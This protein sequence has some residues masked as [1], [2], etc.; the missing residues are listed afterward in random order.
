MTRPG[1]TAQHYQKIAK[2]FGASPRSSMADQY[3][4]QQEIRFIFS[5]I[6]NYCL[7]VQANPTVLDLGCGN[8]HLL[9]C[10][11]SKFPHLAL[12]GLEFTPELWQIAQARQLPGVKIIQGDCLVADDLP[13]VDIIITERVLVNLLT[14]KKQQQAVLNIKE[15]LRPGGHYVMVESFNEPMQEI[16]MAR[17]EFLLPPVTASAHNLYLNETLVEFMAKWGLR[18]IPGTLAC[19]HLS[20]H[21]F[22]SRVVHPALRPAGGKTRFTRFTA[23]FNQALPPGIG[24]Y[25]P[26]LF[27]CFQKS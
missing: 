20:T 5:A 19:N 25:S 9:S 1:I 21:F 18:E 15:A 13:T 10:L 17:Q 16:N 6:K 24:N 2:N 8:G 22:L 4:R 27:R 26:I 3:I 11:R 12:L 7:H 23:F 14:K